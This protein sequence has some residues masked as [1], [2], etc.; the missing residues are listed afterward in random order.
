[1]G[2]RDDS[3]PKPLRN[4]MVLIYRWCSAQTLNGKMSNLTMLRAY[5]Q[6]SPES[7]PPSILFKTSSKNI[8]IFDA[9]PKS[10]FH[11]LILP[12]VQEPKLNAAR[13]DNLR[14]LLSRDKATAR[15]VLYG[16][17]DDAR[18]VKKA[19]EEEMIQ[20]YGFKWEVWM[21]FH[22]APSMAYVDAKFVVDPVLTFRA[23]RKIGTFICT[24][25]L[26]IFARIN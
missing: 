4:R 1:M 8:T 13:L 10:M 3:D 15:E 7:F 18:E 2:F 22:G 21:G 26:G 5:A 6:R 9:Y 11:F 20:R 17:A 19:I 24:Y 23:H 25:S 16:L 14:S 12:R